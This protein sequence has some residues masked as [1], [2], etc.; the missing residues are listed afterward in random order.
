[1]VR[2]FR[3]NVSYA[4]N[5]P[6]RLAKPDKE[7]SP[8]ELGGNSYKNSCFPGAIQNYDIKIRFGSQ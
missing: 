7:F 8:E 6:C 2:I 1:M 3:D 5:V 4:S